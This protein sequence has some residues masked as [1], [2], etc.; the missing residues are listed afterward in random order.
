M[1]EFKDWERA[2]GFRGYVASMRALHVSRGAI[3]N[4]RAGR[5]PH[6]V[7]LAM[8]AIAAGLK[9][10]KVG[11]NI[12]MDNG[13]AG[14]DIGSGAGPSPDQLGLPFDRRRNSAEISAAARR[15]GNA[16][17]AGNAGHGNRS[18]QL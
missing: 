12:G 9:P 5:L 16:K 8:A 10:W 2:M 15:G 4:Y 6:R 13:S 3:T 18:V 11:A 7:R 1:S 17:N 14:A